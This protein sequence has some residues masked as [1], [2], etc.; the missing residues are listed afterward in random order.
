MI[1]SLKLW[2][3]DPNTYVFNYKT[4]G[5]FI[6]ALILNLLA[7]GMVIMLL[8]THKCYWEP[9]YLTEPDGGKKD[10][11]L[12]KASWSNKDCDKYFE[13]MIRDKR[14]TIV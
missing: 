1:E 12:K 10:N 14:I 8:I 6:V 3:D 7:L 4:N 5:F 13:K 2:L 11:V 9:T